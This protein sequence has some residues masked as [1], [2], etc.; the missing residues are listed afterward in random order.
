MSGG[1][2]RVLLARDWRKPGACQPGT[3]VPVR[4]IRL[5]AVH[6]ESAN[7]APF[8]LLCSEDLIEALQDLRQLF[9]GGSTDAL[10]NPLHGQ[11]AHLAD[12]DP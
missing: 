4:S 11:G 5:L 9:L 7:A 3:S 1:A 12:L 6:C 8:V 2:T 10:P